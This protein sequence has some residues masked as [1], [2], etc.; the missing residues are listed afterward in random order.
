MS[1]FLVPGES[2]PVGNKHNMPAAGEAAHREG[3]GGRSK[4]TGVKGKIRHVG[5]FGAR[6]LRH[7]YS[8]SQM[9]ATRSES[10]FLGDGEGRSLS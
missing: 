9:P 8:E 5:E 6:L 7:F 2:C 10:T 3:R 1:V 4:E